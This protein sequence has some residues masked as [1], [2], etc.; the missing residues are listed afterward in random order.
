MVSNPYIPHVDQFIYIYIYQVRY[1]YRILLEI[2]SDY[3]L[4]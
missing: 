3:L 2:H 4:Y 1:D